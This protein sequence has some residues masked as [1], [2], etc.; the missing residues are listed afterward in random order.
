MKREK[1][2]RRVRGGASR[3][4]Q[5]NVQRPWGGSDSK[6]SAFRAGNPGLTPDSG[7][8]LG[9]GHGNPLQYSSLENSMDRG[10]WWATVHGVTKSQTRLSDEHFHFQTNTEAREATLDHIYCGK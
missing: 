8:S 3:L 10:A 5:Q 4:S 1:I 2:K 9:E 6:E 7:R